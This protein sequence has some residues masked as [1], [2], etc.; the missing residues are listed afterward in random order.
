MINWKEVVSNRHSA[1]PML[2]WRLSVIYLLFS[3]QRLLFFL[4]N[5]SYFPQ[6][7]FA[8][9]GELMVSGLKF[10]LTAVL[11]I[12]SLYILLMLFP[13]RSKYNLTFKKFLKF[14][15]CQAGERIQP[16]LIAILKPISGMEPILQMTVC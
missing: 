7:S 1:L 10:D 14:L 11:Y 4:F 6:M 2:V 9:L 5:S 3:L 15:F 12:N 13:I 16:L 8:H